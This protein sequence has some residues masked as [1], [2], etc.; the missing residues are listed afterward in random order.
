MTDFN[1]HQLEIF[2]AV[3]ESGSFTAAGERLYLAQSTVSAHIRRLEESL[4]VELFNRDNTRRT[5]LTQ[6]G[7]KVYH[8]AKKI[9]GACLELAGHSHIDRDRE[10]ELGASTVPSAYLLPR[11]IG[12]FGRS[13]FDGHIHLR[14]GDSSDLVRAV[15]EGE[16][17]LA[18]VG[19]LPERRDITY[20]PLCEDR[21]VLITPALPH[22]LE[23]RERHADGREFLRE[24]LIFR[25]ASSGTQQWIFAYLKSLGIPFG[26]LNVRAHVD[27]SST[28]LDLVREGCGNALMSDLLVGEAERAGEI[29][30]FPLSGDGGKRQLYLISRDNGEISRPA[31][32]FKDFCLDRL[33]RN[34]FGTDKTDV[35]K[36]P[37][38]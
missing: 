33:R 7:R 2:I 6:A 22:Y 27:L 16:L 13:G 10:L 34:Q 8:E 11:L 35:P 37:S 9:I 28:V 3:V 17:Q 12:D 38:T 20:Y 19:S 30:V 5:E 15:V 23:A 4:N 26:E 32:A 29:V 14:Y 21:L 1:L 18:F 24:P 31:A 25:R 36:E